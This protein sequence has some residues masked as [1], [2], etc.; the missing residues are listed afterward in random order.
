MDF[1]NFSVQDMAKTIMALGQKETNVIDNT[2]TYRLD[3][4][5]E[6]YVDT[7]Y[8]TK[9][10]GIEERLNEFIHNNRDD[11]EIDF[12]NSDRYKYCWDLST[13]EY[14]TSLTIVMPGKDF[15]S[16]LGKESQRKLHEIVKNTH[17]LTDLNRLAYT[18]VREA[19]L[20]L[21]RTDKPKSLS[22]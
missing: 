3:L 6:S 17:N 14:I 22:K 11:C 10:A 18:C 16:H 2:V 8:A 21:I 12:H 7:D 5:L 13:D 19:Y 9:F 20:Y 15:N 1:T 4:C